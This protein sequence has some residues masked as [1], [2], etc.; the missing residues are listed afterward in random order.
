MKQSK[1]LYKPKDTFFIMMT[2]NFTWGILG[3]SLGIIIN[4]TVIFIC[5]AFEINLL[6]IQI[7]IQLILC[8]FILALI[9]YLFNYFGWT[10]QNTTAGLFFIS[11]FFGIQFDIFDDIQNDFMF[12][13]IK[14]NK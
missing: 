2:K 4:N 14:I 6:F 11:F 5:N 9:Q 3:I 13:K 12:S 7:T 1:S 8:A 10:W